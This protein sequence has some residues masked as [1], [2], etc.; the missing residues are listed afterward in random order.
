MWYKNHKGMKVYVIVIVFM[1]SGSTNLED[2]YIGEHENWNLDKCKAVYETVIDAFSV[3]P[4]LHFQSQYS[5]CITNAER[6][7]R[8]FPVQHG[9]V[10]ESS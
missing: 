9:V 10:P 1:L 7:R 4:G 2:V 6:R 3:R 5:G 8:D